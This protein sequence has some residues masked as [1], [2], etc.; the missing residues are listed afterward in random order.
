[1]TLSL[2]DRS[3]LLDLQSRDSQLFEDLITGIYQTVLGPG[4]L[5][6]DGGANVGLHTFPMS[7][8]V[9]PDGRVIAVEPL[10]SERA[11]LERVIAQRGIRNVDVVPKALYHERGVVEFT[12]VVDAP[13]SSSIAKRDFGDLVQQHMNVETVLLDDLLADVT[14][15][16]FAKLDL[17]G[18][19]FRALQGGSRAIRR[20]KP[21]VVFEWSV[22]APRWF[23]YSVG[24][25]FD[26]FADHDYRLFDL[27]GD[28]LDAETFA[29][30]GRPWYAVAASVGGPD[31]DFVHSGLPTILSR[32]VDRW[33]GESDS[34]RDLPI[35]A[36]PNPVPA[37][38]GAG[39]T[40]VVWQSG[41]EMAEVYISVNSDDEKLFF[42][43]PAGEREFPWINEWGTYEFRL[44]RG[45]E[46]AELLGSFIVKKR[47]LE[48]K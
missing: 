36:V 40:T 12:L 32:T 8:A 11:K 24:E 35:F 6:L 19:E 22:A 41:C 3:R 18:A 44:Y 2:A 20:H 29:E 9:G 46:R 39:R 17:E 13:T 28:R 27:F 21:L 25:F 14:A 43:S 42:R 37:E 1:M 48:R 23:G 4:D 26:W 33:F 10:A 31:E 30:T 16:R 45:T 34:P 15:W 7:R 38:E 47:K 5:T